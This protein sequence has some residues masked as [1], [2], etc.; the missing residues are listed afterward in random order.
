MVCVFK[1][2]ITHTSG[3][4]LAVTTSQIFKRDLRCGRLELLVL[5]SVDDKL[6]VLLARVEMCERDIR[7]YVHIIDLFACV[8]L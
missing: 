7:T 5:S 1:I 6:S 4:L 2:F 3:L 8:P